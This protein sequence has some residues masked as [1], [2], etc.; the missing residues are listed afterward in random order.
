MLECLKKFGKKGG[1]QYFKLNAME[2]VIGFYWKY[3][4][5]IWELYLKNIWNQ[6]R[7]DTVDGIN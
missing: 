2:N 7:G 4:G 3:M 5:I 1:Y 6:S